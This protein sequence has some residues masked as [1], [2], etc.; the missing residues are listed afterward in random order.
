MIFG[1]GLAVL[2]DNTSDGGRLFGNNLL[3]ETMGIKLVAAGSPN[4]CSQCSGRLMIYIPAITMGF[5]ILILRRAFRSL[6]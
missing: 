6:L 1:I 3:E 2:H 4:Q 5:I